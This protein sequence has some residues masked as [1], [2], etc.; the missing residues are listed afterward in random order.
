MAFLGRIKDLSILVNVRHFLTINELIILK[1]I[2]SHNDLLLILTV[3]LKIYRWMNVVGGA[4]LA[5]RT[6][7]IALGKCPSINALPINLAVA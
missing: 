6:F 5:A 1:L 2:W 7:N 4:V 3:R